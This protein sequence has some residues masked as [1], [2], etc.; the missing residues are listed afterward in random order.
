[1]ALSEHLGRSKDEQGQISVRTLCARL[2]WPRLSMADCSAS[3]PRS[4]PRLLFADPKELTKSFLTFAGLS[5]G[6]VSHVLF[7][8]SVS[9]DLM[10]KLAHCWQI[11]FS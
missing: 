3:G 8:G 10:L 6:E 5:G 9:T 7:Y 1:M 2:W 11:F 4:P